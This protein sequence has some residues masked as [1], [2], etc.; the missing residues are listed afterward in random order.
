MTV[1]FGEVSLC[2]AARPTTAEDGA[3]FPSILS[4]V[5]SVDFVLVKRARG[6]GSARAALQSNRGALSLTA[7]QAAFRSRDR[8]IARSKS[9]NRCRDRAPPD[10]PGQ[11][12]DG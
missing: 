12:R 10:N 5:D 2:R 1:V 6:S 3:V 11:G 7:D 9:H 8:D 4:M